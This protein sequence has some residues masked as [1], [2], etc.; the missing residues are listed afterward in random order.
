ML[1][2]IPRFP[3]K[4][5]EYKIMP[6]NTEGGIRLKWEVVDSMWIFFYFFLVWST[7]GTF[8]SSCCQQSDE[9]IVQ[10]I[11]SL[12]WLTNQMKVLHTEIPY[13]AK[14][15]VNISLKTQI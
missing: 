7:P 12:L 9:A 14:R 15:D 1:R 5:T 10:V 6:P 2:I 11:V 8:I 13:N 3:A 4:G